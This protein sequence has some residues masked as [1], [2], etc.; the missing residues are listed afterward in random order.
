MVVV[1]LGEVCD[2]LEHGQTGLKVSEAA[3]GERISHLVS[4]RKT[5]YELLRDAQKDIDKIAESLSAVREKL[6]MN[7]G[8]VVMGDKVDVTN[9]DIKGSQVGTGGQRNTVDRSIKI[10]VVAIVVLAIVVTAGAFRLEIFSDWL[11][12]HPAEEIEA[13]AE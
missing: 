12:V 13:P 2:E 10:I 8:E 3:H 11:H 5:I 7:R 9:S 6:G 4:D 1:R